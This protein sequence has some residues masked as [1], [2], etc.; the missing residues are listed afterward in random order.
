MLDYA[1]APQEGKGAGEQ[2]LLLGR[3]IEAML[4]IMAE[5]IAGDRPD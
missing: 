5:P 2:A 3:I 4:G 1:V